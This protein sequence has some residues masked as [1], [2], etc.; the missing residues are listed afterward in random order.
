MQLLCGQCGK[1]QETDDDVTGTIECT[2][3]GHSIVMPGE[4]DPGATVVDVEP[5]SSDEG[6]AEIARKAVPRKV[7][8]TCKE[9]DKHFSVSA[10]R[11]GRQG[12]CPACGANIKVPYPDDEMEF[13]L[14]HIEHAGLAGGDDAPVELEVVDDAA[15]DTGRRADEALVLPRAAVRHRKPT[16][17]EQAAA[18]ARAAA[19]AAAPPPA[20]KQPARPNIA[21]PQRP[22]AAEAPPRAPARTATPARATQGDKSTVPATAKTEPRRAWSSKGIFFILAAGVVLAVGAGLAFHF[23]GSRPGDN[24]PDGNT[25][26][27]DPIVSNTGGNGKTTPNGNKPPNGGTTGGNGQKTNGQKTT[28]QNNG[29]GGKT[30]NG[31]TKPP[32]LSTACVVKSASFDMFAA[33]GYFPAP[34]GMVYLKAQAHI[35]VRDSAVAFSPA[36]QD[37]T[38]S[39]GPDT[40]Q[41]LGLLAASPSL[42]PMQADRTPVQIEPGQS[43]DLTFLFLVPAGGPP[44]TLTV[45]GI[46]PAKVPRPDSPRTLDAGALAGKFAE[47]QPRNLKPLLSD[48]V[49]AAIQDNRNHQVYVLERSDTLRVYVTPGTVRGVAKPVGGGM[50]ETVLKHGKDE[51]TCKLRLADGGDT[52]IVYLTDEPFHQMTYTRIKP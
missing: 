20:P 42:V 7:R 39:V 31:H 19:E 23:L 18:L 9:C 32:V 28:G 26:Y 11:A 46:D 15:T 43:R 6:F 50:Y 44:T 13:D 48:P 33:E 14:P 8:L 51:L 27:D 52:L 22:P 30:T 38:L 21:P 1:V 4:V 40:V 5:P 35:T 49:M 37:V 45:A 25:T 29:N 12:R 47:A 10:R 2:H 36:G 34:P 3:C 41:S 24:T 16:A 17:A